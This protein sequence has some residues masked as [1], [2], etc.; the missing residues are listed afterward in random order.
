MFTPALLAEFHKLASEHPVGF[1]AELIPGTGPIER[2][3]NQLDNITFHG[4]VFTSR[5]FLVQTFGEGTAASPVALQAIVGN[6]NLFMSSLQANFW[7]GVV[8]PQ[9]YATLW[10]VDFTVPNNTPLG[11]SA[12]FRVTQVRTDQMVGTLTLTDDTISNTR[13]ARMRR[14]IPSDGFPTMRQI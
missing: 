7:D 12:R 6:A 14:Y 10:L 5:P 3:T 13:N 1:L 8:H 11:Q 9:W 2:V 4:N